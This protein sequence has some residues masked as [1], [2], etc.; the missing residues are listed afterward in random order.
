MLLKVKDWDVLIIG[1]I[2]I[3][4]IGCFL[5]WGRPSTFPYNGG[6]GTGVS[7]L[8]GIVTFFGFLSMAAFQLVF[9]FKRKVYMVKVVLGSGLV[10]L[11][12]SGNWILPLFPFEYGG[13]GT[14]TVLYGA[15]VT[16]LVAVAVS[17]MA[18]LY[19]AAT[20]KQQLSL[21]RST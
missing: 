14:Y 2:I 3:G 15:Y 13:S 8:S 17:G 12:F 1:G 9:M 4:I 19:I 20:A 18:F 7:F 6:L 21:S 16:L 11:L 10:A 5:P